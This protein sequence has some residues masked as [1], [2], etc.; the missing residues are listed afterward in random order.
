MSRELFFKIENDACIRILEVAA[1]EMLVRKK[2]VREEKRVV[3]VKRNRRQ[4]K[5]PNPIDWAILV[6]VS[7]TE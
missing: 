4:K 2:R 1:V 6:V 7:A 3:A 5:S